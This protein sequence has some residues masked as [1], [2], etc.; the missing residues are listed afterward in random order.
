MNVEG[1][2]Y[3]FP[4][5]DYQIQGFRGKEVRISAHQMKAV[6]DITSGFLRRKG[7]DRAAEL[8]PLIEMVAGPG[9]AVFPPGAA[10]RKG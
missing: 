5:A 7:L 4:I 1:A 8:D 9:L 10:G 6:V 3:P 2:G